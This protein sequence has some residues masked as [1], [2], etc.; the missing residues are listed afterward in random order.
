MGYG[1]QCRGDSTGAVTLIPSKQLNQPVSLL[2]QT[3]KGVA[4]GV[5]VTH[6]R[7]T[8]WGVL[9][10]C[11]VAGVLYK[12]ET[13]LCMQLMASRFMMTHQQQVS[14]PVQ[15]LIHKRTL[16]RLI[17]KASLFKRCIVESYLWLSRFKWR[18]NDHEE[19]RPYRS[20]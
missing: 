10:S 19:T 13:N 1:W 2:E 20:E 11:Y 7:T 15:R 17:L 9:A 3:F 4:A 14:Y 5:H 8:A 18:G 12:S 6:L 16:T